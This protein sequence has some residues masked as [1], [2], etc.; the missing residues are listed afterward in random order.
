GLAASVAGLFLGLGLA[1]GLGSLMKALQLD[2]PQ[3]GI[4]FA[5]RTVIVSL[6]V[7]VLITLVATIAPAFRATRVPPI[8]AVREGAVLPRGR[9]AGYRPAIALTTVGLAVALLGYGL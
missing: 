1:K 4:V 6:V 8:S 3:T 9:F 7:G 5:S 2:L